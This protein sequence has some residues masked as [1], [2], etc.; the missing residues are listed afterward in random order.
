MQSIC[1]FEVGVT[2]DAAQEVNI[3]SSGTEVGAV[4]YSSDTA[5]NA[6]DGDL[7]TMWQVNGTNGMMKIV[8][9]QPHTFD[10][11]VLSSLCDANATCSDDGL[12]VYIKVNLLIRYCIRSCNRDK[13]R[14]Q[15]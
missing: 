4:V 8:F 15:V 10:T 13:L 3:L 12:C 14:H 7:S 1:F 6:F 2:W 5:Q 11:V 9:D